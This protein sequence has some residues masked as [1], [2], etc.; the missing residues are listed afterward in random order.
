MT[1]K[2]LIAGPCAVE[3][4]A[5]VQETVQNAK[6]LGVTIVRSNLWKPRTSPGFEGVGEA[7]LPWLQATAQ[8]GLG[9]ALE[10]MTPEQVVVVMESILKV[11]P[12]ATL[13]FW[14]GSR[15]QN[16]LIIREIAHRVAGQPN[17]RLMLKN[18]PWRDERH[19]K[20]MAA[21]ASDGGIS[22]DQLLMCHRGF[23][24]SNTSD[25]PMRNNPDLEMAHKVRRETGLPMILDPSHIGGAVEIV[26]ELALSFGQEDWIDGQIIEVH[27]NPKQAVTDAKQ[28]LTWDELAHIL[29]MLRKKI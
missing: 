10:V 29:P 4:E 8:E 28:Q 21:H 14:I 25:T 5:Q 7:G 12:V 19:W 15:N 11:N 24:P 20:G 6:A 3:S 26:K 23:A 18:Q 1:E 16:H 2:I 17:V 27:P 22:D 9:I 13:L